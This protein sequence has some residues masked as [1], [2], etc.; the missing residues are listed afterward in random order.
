MFI[1]NHF[2]LLYKK[3]ALL[4]LFLFGVDAL[5][6]RVHKSWESRCS[7]QPSERLWSIV[8]PKP[9]LCGTILGHPRSFPSLL[10]TVVSVIPAPAGNCS[11]PKPQW[12]LGEGR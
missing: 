11:F 2:V 9:C 1:K 6:L 12:S 5:A 10:P 3:R 8:G 7:L 4:G